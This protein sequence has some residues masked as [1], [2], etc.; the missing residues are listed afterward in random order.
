[1]CIRDSVYNQKRLMRALEVDKQSSL[2][3][4]VKSESAGDAGQDHHGENLSFAVFNSQSKVVLD[5]HREELVHVGKLG[6][7]AGD[8]LEDALGLNQRG[9]G[10]AR[11]G[12]CYQVLR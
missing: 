11:L 6:L 2:A 5:M 8:A 1:M 10:Q 12:A 3:E 7:H 9:C 4:M